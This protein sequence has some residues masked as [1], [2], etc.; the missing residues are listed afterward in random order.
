MVKSF[1]GNGGLLLNYYNRL[2]APL[3]IGATTS[4]LA[5]VRK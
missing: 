3:R 1:C 4:G 5:K 2:A